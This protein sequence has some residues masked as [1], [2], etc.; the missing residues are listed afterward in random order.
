MAIRIGLD[1][2]LWRQRVKAV[3]GRWN[4]MRRLWEVEYGKV[5]K[6]GLTNRIQSED[7]SA[8]GNVD[9]SKHETKNQFIKQAN[10]SA[11][12]KLFPLAEM[13]VCRLITLL[14]ASLK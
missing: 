13:T 9:K 2:L 4:P 5:R 10:V 7:I 12:G 11:S 14:G 6:L 8:N 3:G 1:E